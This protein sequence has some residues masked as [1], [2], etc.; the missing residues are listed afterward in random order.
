[1]TKPQSPFLAVD[2]IIF[3]KDRTLLIKR[4]IDP[5]KGNWVL[6]G[7]HVEYGERVEDALKREIKEEV[8]IKIKIKK[9]VG[10]Y[11]DPQRDPRYHMVSIAYLCKK[12][13]GSIQL[14]SEASQYK[15][16]SLNELPSKIGFDH[17]KIIMDFRKSLD[18]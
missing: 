10:I 6:P 17:R 4:A 8:G 7:G 1:M 11:S 16:F 2:G 14:S 13:R 3:D 12:I 18:S 5:F 15:Y 9:L